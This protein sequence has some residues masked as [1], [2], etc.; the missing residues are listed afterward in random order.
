MNIRQAKKIDSE[1]VT[2][3]VSDLMIEFGFP[4]FDGRNLDKIYQGMVGGGK[5]GF[6]MLAESDDTICGIC[7]VSFVVSLRTRGVYGIVQ[8]MYI[9]PELRG[10]RIGAKMLISTIEYAQSV[11]AGQFKR[12]NLKGER[13]D[14]YLIL[15][16]SGREDLNLRLPA[17]KAGFLSGT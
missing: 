16:W 14:N 15:L 9:L 2:Q 6:V 13:L 5:H 4:E 7:T 17:P 10:Q 3:M 1:I 12:I 8:E 11:G